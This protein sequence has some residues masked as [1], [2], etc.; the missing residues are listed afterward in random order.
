MSNESMNNNIKIIL[1]GESK[2]GK[3]N[4][5]NTYFDKPFLE[6]LGRTEQCDGLK[7][8][9]EINNKRFTIHIWDTVGNEV[10]RS[11]AK[12]Y[13]RNT[14]IVIFVYDITRKDT[15]YELNYWINLVTEELGD[16]IV[17]GL[18]GNKNDL[19]LNE[20][21]S[22]DEGESEAKRINA[23]FSE[24]SAKVNPKAFEELVL[25]LLGKLF[26]LNNIIN[27]E[28]D[29]NKMKI[30]NRLVKED[31]NSNESN[32]QKQKNCC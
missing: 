1:L 20:E 18:A 15:F 8:E 9:V 3:T 11:L 13:L 28:E 2:V 14:H 30:I 27:K 23:I 22:K 29:I 19:F 21:V 7:R 31:S 24:T 10:Y 6:E 32:K 12:N 17:F 25:K 26:K 16:N 4:L 5:I